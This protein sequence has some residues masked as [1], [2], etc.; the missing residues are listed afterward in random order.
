MLLPQAL[1]VI[2]GIRSELAFIPML[3]QAEHLDAITSCGFEMDIAVAEDMG[4]LAK[5][6]AANVPNQGVP[7]AQ[8]HCIAIACDIVC[9]I[10]GPMPAVA[11]YRVA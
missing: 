5:A 3:L 9:I 10:V 6:L 4:A 11:N 1:N 8:I 2:S 7:Q